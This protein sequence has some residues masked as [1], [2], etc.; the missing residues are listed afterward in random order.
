MCDDFGINNN[1]IFYVDFLHDYMKNLKK[2]NEKYKS[3]RKYK[4]MILLY[5]VFLGDV[6]FLAKIA[7]TDLINDFDLTYQNLI[8]NKENVSKK[9]N[10]CLKKDICRIAAREGHLHI[11]KWLLSLLSQIYLMDENYP[12]LKIKDNVEVI[13]LFEIIYRNA[14]ICGHINILKWL[15]DSQFDLPINVIRPKMEIGEY[16]ICKFAIEGDH[17][18]I[19][20]W[21]IKRGCMFHYGHATL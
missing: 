6:S 13:D 16:D 3:K 20:E 7:K 2:F 10:Y 4:C 5:N 18:E 11:L 15:S 19:L 14:T 9:K 21:G 12:E 8:Q 1:I 17:L